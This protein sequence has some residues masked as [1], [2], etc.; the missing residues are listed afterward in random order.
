MTSSCDD[1]YQTA[2]YNNECSASVLACFGVRQSDGICDY[3]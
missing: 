3:A 1:A 2:F